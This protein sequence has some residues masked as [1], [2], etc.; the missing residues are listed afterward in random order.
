MTMAATARTSFTVARPLR[1]AAAPT[2]ALMALVS[3]VEAA[4]RA[5]CAG[6]APVLPV[7]GLA[8]YLLMSLFHLAPWLSPARD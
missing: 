1:L 8:M 7:G 4:P 3:V 5:V 6:G 2:F